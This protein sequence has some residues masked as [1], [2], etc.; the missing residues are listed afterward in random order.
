MEPLEDWRSPQFEE[1][2]RRLDR[3]GISF[4]FLRRNRQY[5]QDYAAKLAAISDGRS[6]ETEAIGQ[7]TR[8]WG[9]RFP[10]DPS[11]SA[12]TTHP[13]WQPRHF[14]AVL[15][16]AAAPDGFA[17]SFPDPKTLIVHSDA[18]EDGLHAVI[19]DED[20][21]HRLW[22]PK[23]DSAEAAAIRIPLDGHLLW[24][25]RSALRLWRRLDG[26]PS[27]PW[28]REQRLSPFQL[29]RASLM[30]RAWDGVAAGV[31]RRHVAA[32]LLNKDVEAL[33]ALDWKNAPERR[34]LA[35]I[36]TA[37]RETIEDGYLRW[38][39]PRTRGR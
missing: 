19:D 24:R 7:L 21:D 3:G 10:A 9:L 32:V 16:I 8:H 1:Q 36:L 18:A 20:G 33:R 39:V 30:L 37:A 23:H 38:L 17:S 31:S 34:R 5:Q 4:E 26:E 28:P 11:A 25:V 15:T 12:L 22:F 2:L 35:R 6:T 13:I 27:G 14:P 29:H